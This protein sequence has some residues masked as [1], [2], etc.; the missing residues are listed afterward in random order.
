MDGLITNCVNGKGNEKPKLVSLACHN[1]QLLKFV[2]DEAE[3]H[4]RV[5]MKQ[6]ALCIGE[7]VS[8]LDE[9][10]KAEAPQLE[11]YLARDREAQAK[12]GTIFHPSVTLNDRTFRGDYGDPND[13]F[14]VICAASIAKPEACR[15]INLVNQ[16]SQAE[17]DQAPRE[18]DAENPEDL[19]K[20]K[21]KF[22]AEQGSL[23]GLERLA[24]AHNVILGLA[25][26]CLLNCMCIV[27][28][29][30]HDRK[31]TSHRQRIRVNETVAQYFALAADETQASE[32]SQYAR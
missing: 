17:V 2:G 29:K 4:H 31:R 12:V 21:E 18:W 32:L 6:Y 25:T 11:S 16:M 10:F 15:K 9:E 14:K 8:L 24:S 26:V 7:Q 23:T 19:K 27:F 13:L 1:K 3:Q 22:D 30:L 20:A 5:N 28:C